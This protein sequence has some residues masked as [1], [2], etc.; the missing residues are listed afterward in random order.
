MT[1]EEYLEHDALALAERVRSRDVLPVELLE[2][3]T[4]RAELLNPDINAVVRWMPEAAEAALRVDRS[5]PFCGVPFLAKDLVSDYEGHPTSAGSRLL[6]DFPVPHDSEVA[7][8]VRAAGLLVFGKTNVPEWG[9]A[10]YT[11]PV[12]WG[13]CRNPWDTTR[14]PGG[15]SGGSAAAVS[16]GVVPMAGGG[17][18]GGSIRIPASCCGLFG[19]KPTRGR[20]PTGPDHGQLWRGAVVEHV[21]TR[22][23][24]DSAAMLDAI[25]GADPGA[26]YEITR[27]AV[28]YLGEVSRDPPRLRIA[29]T[30]RPLL[31]SSVH[32][33]CVAAVEDAVELLEQLGHELREAAPGV[34]GPRFSRSFVQVIAAELAADLEEASEALRRRPHRRENEPGSWALALLGREITARE[35]ASG[36]RLLE[37]T[38][39]DLGIFLEEHQLL[40]T[41][42]VAAPPPPIGSMAPTPTEDRILR[43]LG[44]IGSGKVVRAAGLLDRLAAEVFDFIPWTPLFN[45]GGQP[46][47]SVPLHWN[48]DGL[49]V[50]VHL[51]AR[52]GRE[53]VLF[54][55]AGQLER[56]RPWF[57]RL[58]EVATRG[59]SGSRR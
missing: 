4:R 27:P 8:R 5:A 18:G 37:R 25:H 54:R 52:F 26:P 51:A 12:L 41:P 39:R 48:A 17:D 46:A 6:A 20:V 29:Y 31:G 36:L 22:S 32:P 56:A 55:L 11:E 16:A 24:R 1:H 59:L 7:R 49:P 58:P 15:S 43:V 2:L 10:P 53:D 21:L 23:V 45:I 42:T 35:Y 40:L 57:D 28:P 19:L 14:T 33:D 47:M 9:L 34:D 50:G 3:A 30:T 13:P 44:A 38:G